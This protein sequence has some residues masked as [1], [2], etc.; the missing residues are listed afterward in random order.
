MFKFFRFIRRHSRPINEDSA[1]KW[2]KR[3]NVTYIFLSW[4]VLGFVL[5][6]HFRADKDKHGKSIFGSDSAASWVDYL[7]LKGDTQV[8]NIHG[9]TSVN[10]YRITQSQDQEQGPASEME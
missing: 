3:L 9:L 5:Y 7:K 8:V 6:C 4:N 10:S 2:H 1:T